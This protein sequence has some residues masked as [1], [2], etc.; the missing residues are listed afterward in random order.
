MPTIK[1]I[2]VHLLAI[3]GVFWIFTTADF[4]GEA[5]ASQ[6]KD[7]QK[8]GPDH[9][10]VDDANARPDGEDVEAYPDC[11]LSQVVWMTAHTP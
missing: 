6:E 11:L 5:G 3:I 7:D 8:Q 10:P 1:K 4:F 9:A 2:L